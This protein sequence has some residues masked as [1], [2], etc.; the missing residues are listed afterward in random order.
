MLNILD[1]K[2]CTEFLVFRSVSDIMYY[3]LLPIFKIA[4]GIEMGA[5]AIS[6]NVLPYIAVAI[7]SSFF[8]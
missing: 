6:G 1:C 5:V 8:F 2:L 4:G 7:E 3:Y